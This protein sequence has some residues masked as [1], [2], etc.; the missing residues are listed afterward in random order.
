[1]PRY[2][3]MR[4]LQV[5]LTRAASRVIRTGYADTFPCPIAARPDTL[6]RCVYFPA[7]GP[8]GQQSFLPPEYVADLDGVEGRVVR[9]APCTAAE[10]GCAPPLPIIPGAGVNP[11]MSREEYWRRRERAFDLMPVVWE[12]FTSG[13]ARTPEASELLATILTIT[14]LAA[15]PFQV[16]PTYAFFR[17]MGL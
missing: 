14:P 11:G 7:G 12:Q 4:Q 13:A 16:L 10:V 1:M 3:P 5:A 8:P 17:W 2:T 15:A 6:L 9:L